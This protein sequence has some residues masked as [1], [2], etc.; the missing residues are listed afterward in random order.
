MARPQ[1]LKN[2]P[3]KVRA[4]GAV[5]SLLDPRTYVHLMKMLHYY[6]YSHASQLRKMKVGSNVR[7]A[8]TVSLTNAEHITLGDNVELSEFSTVWAS[9]DGG[10]IT[11]EDWAGIGPYCFVTAAKYDN[12]A[13]RIEERPEPVGAGIRIGRG[14]RIYA[15][16]MIMAGTSIGEGAIVGPGSLVNSDIPPYAIAMGS[17][18]RVVLQ[19]RPPSTES[20]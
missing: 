15:N 13:T 20:D 6:N 8:P 4:L 2:K 11:I 17:P 12:S 9:A 18:A 1:R 16:C 5:M 10:R 14:A 3:R 7:I 19:R